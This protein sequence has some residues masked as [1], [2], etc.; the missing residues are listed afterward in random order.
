MET[1]EKEKNLQASKT[2]LKKVVDRFKTLQEQSKQHSEKIEMLESS[3]QE[4]DNLYQNALAETE[5]QGKIF[6]AEVE[7]LTKKS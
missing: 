2:K 5:E 3:L 4:K 1:E 6:K 7:L